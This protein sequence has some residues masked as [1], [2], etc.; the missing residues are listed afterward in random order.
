MEEERKIKFFIIDAESGELVEN[1]FENETLSIYEERKKAYLDTTIE[2]NKKK[3]FTKHIDLACRELLDILTLDEWKILNIMTTH[4]GYGMYNGFV[5]KKQYNRF[6]DFMS[7]KDIIDKVGCSSSTF[8]RAIKKFKENEILETKKRGNKNT[9]ILN[10]FLFT[11][12]KRIP[13]T[14]FSMFEKSKYNYLQEKIPSPN[15]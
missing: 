10:P 4:L 6:F 3:T 13:K 2:L 11:K 1:V 9:F 5:I 8:K 7:S 12:D 15:K 14:L